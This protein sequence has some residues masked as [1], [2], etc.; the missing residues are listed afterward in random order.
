MDLV[1]LEGLSFWEVGKPRRAENGG[2]WILKKTVNILGNTVGFARFD[3]PLIFWF[4]VNHLAGG[5]FRM[6]SKSGNVII[7]VKYHREVFH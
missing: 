6:F 4:L 5:L 1:P 2:L 3:G 7:K